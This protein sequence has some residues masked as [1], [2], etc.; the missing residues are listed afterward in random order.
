MNTAIS[1]SSRN[2]KN[3]SEQSELMILL[4]SG[5]HKML[6]TDIPRSRI[7]TFSKAHCVR[8]KNLTSGMTKKN[9]NPELALLKKKILSPHTT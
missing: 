7:V 4:V 8:Q 5:T 9:L 3:Q 6:A 2:L 1:L